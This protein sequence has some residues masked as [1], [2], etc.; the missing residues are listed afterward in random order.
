MESESGI[1]SVVLE[2]SFG[3]RVCTVGRLLQQAFLIALV[4]GLRSLPPLHV[5]G[6]NVKFTHTRLTAG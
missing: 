4:P 3:V 1:T 2:S 6:T 5:K